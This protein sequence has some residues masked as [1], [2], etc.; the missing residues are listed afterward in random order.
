MNA[1]HP[2]F[3]DADG[4]RRAASF[5][6][7]RTWRYS[8]DR[9]WDPSSPGVLWLLLNPSTADETIDD[10]T[11]RRAIGFSKR[12]GYG[13]LTL[14]N[15]F[16][17]RAT[18]PKDMKA[19]EDPVGEANDSVILG[20][21]IDYQQVICAWG[22]HGTFRGRAQEVVAMLSDREQ[23]TGRVVTLS[24]LGKTKHGHPKHPLYLRNDTPLETYP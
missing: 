2:L 18:D 9:V 12:E 1:T 16:A 11:I 21:A 4:M 8:L 13:S 15:L 24:C 7:C 10:P 23:T 5:S 17:Y 3:P 22:V 20:H 6:R 14:L 19:A